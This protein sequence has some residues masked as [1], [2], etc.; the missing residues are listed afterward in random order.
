MPPHTSVIVDLDP[1]EGGLADLV[2]SLDARSA[3]TSDFEVIS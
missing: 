1:D 3:D 2:R